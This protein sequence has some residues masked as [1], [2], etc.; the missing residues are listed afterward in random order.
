MGCSLAPASRTLLTS[1]HTDRTCR[2]RN[3]Q[4]QQRSRQPQRRWPLLKLG[5]GVQRRR[6][7]GC[8]TIQSRRLEILNAFGLIHAQHRCASGAKRG[9]TGVRSG[10]TSRPTGESIVETA[11]MA[12]CVLGG[13]S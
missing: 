12:V 6:S 9:A 2:A 10:E 4:P 8:I 3:P 1:G 11:S 5:S 13:Q 7:I